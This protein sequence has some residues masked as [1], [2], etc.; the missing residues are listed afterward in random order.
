MVENSAEYKTLIDHTSEL[1]VAVRST[2]VSLSGA[3]LASRLISFD[4]DIEL[5]DTA[6]SEVERS[7]KLI[8]LV[9]DKVRLNTRH[10]HSFIGILRGNQDRYS[11]ILQLLEQTYGSY[12]QEDGNV[13]Y[14][15]HLELLV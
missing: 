1:R 14:I 4:N 9:Q 8:E 7:A 5:R 2:L 11:D 15:I 3:L 10:Y 12:Q 13:D 6:H